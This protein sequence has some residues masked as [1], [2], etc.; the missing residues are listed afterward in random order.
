MT[1]VRNERDN[2]SNGCRI[3]RQNFLFETKDRE[4]ELA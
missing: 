4:T 3:M 1:K 2:D